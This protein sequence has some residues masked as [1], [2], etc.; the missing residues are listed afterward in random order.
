M[1]YKAK[2][3]KPR[4]HRSALWSI[5]QLKEDLRRG[6]STLTSI[7]KRYAEDESK[8]RALYNDVCRWR[9]TDPELEELLVVNQQKTDPKKRNAIK[10]GRPKNDEAEEHAD[11]RVK[12]CEE[13]LKSKSRNKA[14][15]VT[16]YSPEQI[17]QK[18]NEKYT[19]YD[20][21]FTEMVHL[22]EMRMVAW[23]EEEM[24]ASLGDAEHPKDRAWIAKEILKV[25]DRLRWG[26]KLDV[27]VQATHTHQLIDRGKL[28]GQLEEERRMFFQN[29]PR[30]QISDGAVL[31]AEVVK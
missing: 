2:P 9:E 20:A 8:W 3:K 17:Y 13:L 11:W 24:W 31:E 1:A 10:G 25:R 7:C 27:N 28:L 29:S 23:A 16:P 14:A 26:D 30:L 15:L 4:S 22:T 6:A 19:D 18:L 5:E 12:Y 21:A